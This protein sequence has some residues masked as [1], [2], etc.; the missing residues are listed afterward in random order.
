MTPPEP[1]GKERW[2]SQAIDQD[3][4]FV[5]HFRGLAKELEMAI[6]LTYL[7]KWPVTPRN[8]LSLIDR[9]GQI[10]A[11]LRQGPHLRFRH[12]KRR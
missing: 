11:D 6:A 2:R 7:E 1:G 8:S 5:A 3:S 10:A 4:P 12:E 9:H